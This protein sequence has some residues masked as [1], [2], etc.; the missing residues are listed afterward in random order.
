MILPLL[1]VT[2][3]ACGE[4]DTG[5]TEGSSGEPTVSTG[6]EIPSEDT[7]DLEY[8]ACGSL[9]IPASFDGTPRELLI[10]LFSSLPPQGPPNLIL[11][12][13]ASPS[14]GANERYPIR[15]H[16]FLETGEYFVYVSL[17]MDGGGE[18]QP[19]PGV[20]YIGQTPTK[21][22]FDGVALDFGEIEMVLA[23]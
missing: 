6:P 10:A 2:L 13:I 15:V 17:Y 12:R 11:A 19:V 9:N 8:S 18:F 16:P 3:C 20:D 21:I 7:C 4:E 23:E 14:L 22:N 1:L 5:N